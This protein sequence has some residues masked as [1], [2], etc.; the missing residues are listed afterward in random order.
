MEN[1]TSTL[2]TNK[3]PQNLNNIWKYILLDSQNIPIKIYF[4]IYY[5]QLNCIFN[6]FLLKLR[7]LLSNINYFFSSSFKSRT[8]IHR[9][10][11][12]VQHRSLLPCH[13]E[14]ILSGSPGK[15]PFS[16]TTWRRV[17]QLFWAKSV[18]FMQNENSDIVFEIFP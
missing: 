9:G 3:N 11:N 14:K 5:F 6:F 1:L 10:S 4:F 16:L 2:I 12:T 7:H 18:I 13:L 15:N 17:L 8:L